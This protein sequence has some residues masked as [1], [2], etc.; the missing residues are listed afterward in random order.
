[1]RQLLRQMR[2]CEVLGTHSLR[3]KSCC[4][5]NRAKGPLHRL[6]KTNKKLTLPYIQHSFDK[7]V[8]FSKGIG[9][10][11]R[12]SDMS[13]REKVGREERTLVKWSSLQ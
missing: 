9:N 6:G 1:M 3:I 2:N 11:Q 7:C 10:K 8:R 5:L 12:N 4:N 13:H